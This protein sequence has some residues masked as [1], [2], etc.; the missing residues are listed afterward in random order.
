MNLPRN[1]NPFTREHPLWPNPLKALRNTLE[2][3]QILHHKENNFGQKH[4]SETSQDTRLE[5]ICVALGS[6][7]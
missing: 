1:G 2:L 6:V 7:D 4:L 3:Y 5:D